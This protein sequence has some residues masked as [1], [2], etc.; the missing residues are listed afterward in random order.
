MKKPIMLET[1]RDFAAYGQ[2]RSKGFTPEQALE[3]YIL[4]LT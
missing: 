2:L 4:K 1:D 3:S